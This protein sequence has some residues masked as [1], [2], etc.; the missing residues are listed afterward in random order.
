LDGGG[1]LMN[2]GVHTVDL[3]QWLGGGVESVMGM[4]GVF[5]HDI[6]AED[7]TV[8]LLKFKNGALGTLYTTTC[9]YPGLDQL[10]TIYGANGS[11]MKDASKLLAWKIQG[12][13]E[14]QEEKDMLDVFGPKEDKEA[15]ISADPMAVS[16]DGHTLIV[17][18]LVEAINDGRDPMIGLES[19]RHAVEI[20]TAIFESGRTGREVKV[21]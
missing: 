11:V 3:I 8:A 10:I 21:G 15:G 7:Q 19:A 9:C 4:F 5:G 16:A 17:E 20:I 18:D 1:S 12:D 14:S 6:E 2:Q 13:N